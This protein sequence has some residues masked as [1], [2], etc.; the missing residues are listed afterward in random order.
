MYNLNDCFILQNDFFP[1]SYLVIG[2]S[3]NIKK[4]QLVKLGTY[5]DEGEIKLPTGW[6]ALLSAKNI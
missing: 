6:D 4:K 2:S 5:V 1:C 3:V